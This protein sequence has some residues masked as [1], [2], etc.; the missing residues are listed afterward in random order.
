MGFSLFPG[1]VKQGHQMTLASSSKSGSH[2]H[3]ILFSNWMIRIPDTDGQ[4]E[5][6]CLW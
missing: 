5:S 6:V 2:P 1:R 3:F 4:E